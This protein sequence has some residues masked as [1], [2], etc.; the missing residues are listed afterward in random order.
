[1]ALDNDRLTNV[2]Y[3]IAPFI[4]HAVGV[5]ERE[6]DPGGLSQGIARLDPQ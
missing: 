4:K 5:L 6:W 2:L 1:M 3:H